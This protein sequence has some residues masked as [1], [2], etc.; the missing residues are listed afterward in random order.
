[1]AKP[2]SINSWNACRSMNVSDDSVLYEFCVV[3]QHMPLELLA[4]MPPIVQAD[5]L[6]GSGPS[7]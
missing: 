5:A 3:P 7:R 4:T 6:A 1:M 2:P